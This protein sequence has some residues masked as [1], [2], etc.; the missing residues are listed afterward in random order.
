MRLRDA[1]RL[2][3]GDTVIA[4]RNYRL[5]KIVRISNWDKPLFTIKYTDTGRLVCKTWRQLDLTETTKAIL[6]IRA[7][8]EKEITNSK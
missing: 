1:E 4:K 8:E 2:Q 3:V 5:A 7:R 6:R